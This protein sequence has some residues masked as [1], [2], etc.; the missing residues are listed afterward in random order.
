MALKVSTEQS[1]GDAFQGIPDTIHLDNE[2]AAKPAVFRHVMESLGVEVIT[3]MPAGSDGRRTAARAKGTAERPFR[4]VKDAHET[5]YHFHAPETEAEANLWL[6]RF[7]S[8]YNRGDH[9]SEPDSRIGGWLAYLPADGIRQMCAWDRFCV[10]AR[11]PKRRLAGIGCRLMAAGV[12]Y[13]VD[14]GLAEL[15][16]ETGGGCSIRSFGSSTAKS[17]AGRSCQ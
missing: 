8:T 17:A 10:F 4:T 15:A 13:E 2:P 9:G 6:A 7:V 1:G 3:H 11:E 12:T 5:L 16:G 14:A